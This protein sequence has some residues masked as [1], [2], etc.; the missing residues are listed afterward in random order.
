VFATG[1]SE[2]TTYCQPGAYVPGCQK[3]YCPVPQIDNGFAVASTN[4]IFQ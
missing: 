1:V 4:V 3:V 2:I